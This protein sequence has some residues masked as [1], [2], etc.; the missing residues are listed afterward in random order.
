MVEEIHHP[1][2]LI[3][4]RGTASQAV[5]VMMWK[6]GF[7]LSLSAT[8]IF[9]AHFF[10]DAGCS[11][12]PFVC[13]WIVPWAPSTV[14]VC[15]LVICRVALPVPSTAGM[16][17]SRA[18]IEPWLSGPPISVTTAEAIANS[19]VQAGVVM[20]AT[21]ISPGCKQRAHHRSHI[22]LFGGLFRPPDPSLRKRPAGLR[23]PEAFPPEQHTHWIHGDFKRLLQV[24]APPLQLA[25]RDV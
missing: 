22:P 12:F 6:N 21:R 1:N 9:A 4:W 25:N 10:A 7:Y 3:V 15:P 16:P 18:T 2:G 5:L 19:G 13:S 24:L 11:A 20:P 23:E 17:Y 8:V 14:I